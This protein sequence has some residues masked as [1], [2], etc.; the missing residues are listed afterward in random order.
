M[1]E[2]FR[3]VRYLLNRRRYDRELA[4][5]MEFHREMAGRDGRNFGSTLRLRE[6]ARDAWGWT[7]LD[8]FGQDLRYATRVLLK[9]PGF[10]L[11]AVLTLAAG[12]GVNVAAF[13]FFDL[14]ALRPLP[15]REP[16]T[17]LRFQRRSPQ[18]YSTHVSYPALEFYREH[19][20]SLSAVFGLA[21]T[22]LAL[23]GRDKL[24]RADFVTANYL[25]ELGAPITLG[26]GF[27]PGSDAAASTQSVVVLSHSLWESQ[28]ASDP[29]IVG[30]TVRLNERSATVIGVA[31]RTFGGL[32][33]GST[34]VWLPILSQPYYFRGSELLTTISEDSV[35]M[36]GRLRPGGTPE[37]AEAEM[38]SLTAELRKKHPSAFWE[39]EYLAS[40]P[41]GY[42]MAAQGRQAKGNGSGEHHKQEI[43]T[44]SALA[45][46]LVMLILAV[47]CGNLGNLLL[48]RGVARERE[49]AIRVS[50]GAGRGRLLRQLF[51]ESLLLAM[52][53]S[54]AG[55]A[56]GALT[57]R[58][59]IRN[60]N[61]PAWLDPSPDWRMV[62]FALFI[63]FAAAMLFGFTPALQ[64]ARQRHR[65]T[66]LRQ[67]LIGGQVAG[68][69]VLLIVAGL[70]VRALD[71]MLYSN[72]GFE[73][74]QVVAIDPRLV[75]HGYAPENARS[76]LRALQDRLRA[77]PGVA[78]VAL[79]THPPLGRK[80]TVFSS[81]TDGRLTNIHTNHVDSEFF[82]TMRIPILRGRPFEAGDTQT[83]V[84]SES[85]ARRLWP[86]G[87]ELGKQLPMGATKYTVVGVAGNARA[88][89]LEDPDAVECYFLAGA[90]DLPGASVLVRSSV[91]PESITAM[92]RT[93]SKATDPKVTPE[94]ELL[95]TAF[96]RRLEGVQRSALAVTL[97]GGIALLLACLGIV[98]LVA[99]A[100]SQRTKEIGIRMALGAVPTQV[101]SLVLRQFSR[102]V[103]I[104]LLI[105][106]AGAAALSQLL[107][108]Q[109]YG[110]SH[111]DPIAYSAAVAVFAI[112]AVLASLVPA[113]RALRV[114]PLDALRH[115]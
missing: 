2:L 21:Q 86:N 3:R 71:R 84:V 17:I 88:M 68:S 89:A 42:V 69:C 20:R 9:S 38:K 28:F 92:I 59:L 95:R 83:A 35:M 10:T 53:G 74:K 103:V 44:I 79:A 62:A 46:C 58:L 104:G 14:F 65:A 94:I 73:Y 78:S 93:V 45:G 1:T 76:Y 11:T 70:L 106:I 40:E 85:M 30:K 13:G 102:P 115:D 23:E 12:I 49:I 99:Y 72:P 4:D 48:A 19:S 26:N 112:A 57:L 43:Y 32:T 36:W 101:L 105:G 60:T 29:S 7:W 22:R 54:V 50:V 34:D 90:A 77:A 67:I 37:L 114:N 113:R 27:D 52:L 81:D 18:N 64:I 63:G 97:L 25:A 108:R 96:G 41:G 80:A 31:A 15:V 82:E 33:S 51:T 110:V 47:A 109:L 75:A 61:A 16:E 6:E 98:G 91:A 24:L 107:R 66:A 87:D 100:V 5:D 39:R 55:L 56:L 111:L 8:R